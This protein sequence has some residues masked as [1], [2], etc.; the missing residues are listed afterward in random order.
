MSFVRQ[1]M[2]VSPEDFK[3][4]ELSINDVKENGSEIRSIFEN[5]YD[6][7]I[8]IDWEVDAAVE[9][10]SILSSRWTIE[11]LATLYI[12]GESRFNQLRTLLRG[13]SS[14]PLSDKLTKCTENGLVERL[15][16][17]GPPIRVKY[18]LTDHGRN[19]GKLLSPLVAYMK[20]KHG[21]VM[22]NNA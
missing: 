2:S 4:L 17:D 8:D 9:A 21:R 14:R 11:I 22:R 18:R 20:I 12:I 15:V 16:E 5:Y 19:A 7:E 6:E 3:K 1:P 13:I 10:F